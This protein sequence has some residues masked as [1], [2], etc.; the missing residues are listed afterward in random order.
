MRFK[1]K[2]REKRMPKVI[3]E[4]CHGCGICLRVCPNQLFTLEGGKA[5]IFGGR[6]LGCGHCVAACPV[7]AVVLNDLA[8]DL[9]F[10]TFH[11]SLAA[12]SPGDYDTGELVRLMRSR[13]SC[14]N[15]RNIPVPPELLEDLVKIGTTAPSGTNSQRWTFTVLPARKAVVTLGNGVA[16][17][18]KKL[19]RLADFTA[20]RLLLKIIGKKSLDNYYHRYSRTIK[21]GLA[22]WEENDRDRLFHGAPAA[23]IVGS[24]PG[25]SCPVEDALLATQNILL[26]AHSLGLGSCLIGF[27]VAAMAK[28]KSL[29]RLIGIPAEETVHAVIALGFPDEAYRQ[30]AGRRV[31]APRYFQG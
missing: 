5:Y 22:D 9:H 25:A 23:I 2:E 17:Y 15:Y 21:K 30:V 4:N 7:Q 18:F 28:E 16:G 6:C 11:S 31:V 29:K 13:R 20:L 8:I 24:D 12:L 1:T 27:A 3:T 19:N 26:A 10:K 14:R